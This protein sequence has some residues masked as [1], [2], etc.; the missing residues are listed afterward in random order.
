MVCRQERFE[1]G[2]TAEVRHGLLG[3]DDILL[4]WGGHSASFGGRCYYETS[5]HYEENWAETTVI[6]N[7]SGPTSMDHTPLSPICAYFIG[8]TLV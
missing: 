5:S 3:L 7:T 2:K 8:Y 1:A 6:I 4:A